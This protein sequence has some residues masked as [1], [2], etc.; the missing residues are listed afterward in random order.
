MKTSSFKILVSTYLFIS[1][2]TMFGQTTEDPVSTNALPLSKLSISGNAYPV[3]AIGDVHKS[4]LV[5]YGISNGLQMELHGF[6]DTYLQTERFRTNLLGKVY[7][8]EKLYLLSGLEVEVA[9]E[10]QEL[11]EAPYRLGFV[12]GTG[13]D[14]SDNFMVEM[15]SN[16]QLNKDAI[17][18][19]GEKLIEM[20]AVHTIGGKW[21]F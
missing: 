7:L 1:V 6:Y 11:M 12:A 20:P 16:V 9:T 17:G 15:K 21:R 10:S 18:A 14:I 4:F 13:Y 5:G 3:T 19:F 8:T 2:S